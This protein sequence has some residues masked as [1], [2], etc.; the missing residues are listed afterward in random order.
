MK[1]A[2]LTILLAAAVIAAFTV[3]HAIQSHRSGTAVTMRS[4]LPALSMAK[5]ALNATRQHREWVNVP[6]SAGGVRAFIVYPMRADKAPV[7]VV[8]ENRQSAGDWIRAVA[9]QLA[10]EGFI[11][12]VPDV[13]SG[14]APNGGDADS[15]PN[16]STIAAAIERLGGVEISR[17]ANAAR[18][19]AVTLPAADGKTASVEFDNGQSTFVVAADDNRA[20]FPANAQGWSQMVAFLNG[21]TGN[22]PIFGANPNLRRIIRPTSQW[23]WRKPRMA[24]K[25][26]AAVSAAAVIQPASCPTCRRASSTLT[27][28]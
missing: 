7:V 12:V 13:L 14:V 24:A 26:A 25:R 23:R 17:R 18:D 28:R 27:R 19:F 16:P 15:F 8:T 5:M 3:Q 2:P 1:K 21:Q 20:A 22:H 6:Y 9:D 11:A 4:S 10:V